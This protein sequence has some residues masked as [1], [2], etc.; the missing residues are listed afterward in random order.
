LLNAATTTAITTTITPAITTTASL[1]G[2][3]ISMN[4]E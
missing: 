2:T 1:F 4:R 3:L